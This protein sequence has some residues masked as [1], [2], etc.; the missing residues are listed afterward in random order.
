[1]PPEYVAG[2]AGGSPR[3]AT[4]GV[5]VWALPLALFAVAAMVLQ[6]VAFGAAQLGVAG[7]D[8]L[9]EFDYPEIYA[10]VD[11][12]IGDGEPLLGMEEPS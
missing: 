1:M 2:C 8:V 10:P 4:A 7:N 12:G 5:G 6:F 9:M 11:L 3:G